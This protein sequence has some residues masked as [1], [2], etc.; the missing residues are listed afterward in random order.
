MWIERAVNKA[1]RDNSHP[2]QVNK[3]TTEVKSI[4]IY[5]QT[6]PLADAIL[7]ADR[8]NTERMELTP[9]RLDCIPFKIS[10]LRVREEKK[11]KKER[12]SGRE[13]DKWCNERA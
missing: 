2:L 13:R 10:L 7:L 9:P 1:V 8:L 5:I 12:R 4:Y 11:E 3:D 6:F